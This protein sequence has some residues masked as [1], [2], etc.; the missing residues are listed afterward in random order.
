MAANDECLYSYSFSFRPRGLSHYTG[1]DVN[2]YTCP[3]WRSSRVSLHKMNWLKMVKEVSLDVA[4]SS[5]LL[6][7]ACTARVVVCTSP[8]LTLTTA[9]LHFT[10]TVCSDEL[11]VSDLA[12]Q[13]A[14][15]IME[16]TCNHTS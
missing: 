16:H 5:I 7:H 10:A 12:L 4:L 13:W 14:A 9:G 15:C 1:D 8:W 6:L 3:M 11:F 2:W